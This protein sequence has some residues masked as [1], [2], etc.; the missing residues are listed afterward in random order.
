MSRNEI[1]KCVHEVSGLPY[2]EC[3]KILKQNDWD[4]VKVLGL[5]GGF[6]EQLAE[7]LK[8]V[9]EAL[10]NLVEVIISS[11]DWKALADAINEAEKEEKEYD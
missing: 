1:I 11:V 9:Y 10:L 3:R 8:P 5:D 4:M 7:A 2:S 6:M